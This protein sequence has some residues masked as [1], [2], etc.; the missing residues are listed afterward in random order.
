MSAFWR[1]VVPSRKVLSLPPAVG[2]TY[3]CPLILLG[4]LVTSFFS[5]FWIH[6][7]FVPFC[8]F[9]SPFVIRAILSLSLS[10]LDTLKVKYAVKFACLWCFPRVMRVD[11]RRKYTDTSELS[12]QKGGSWVKVWPLF[13]GAVA[14]A[15]QGFF[16]EP[17]G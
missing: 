3:P 15:F 9:A 17:R 1:I 6:D 12:D 7:F 13:E 5:L 8:F 14:R 11:S 10:Q 2:C 16:S 4:G